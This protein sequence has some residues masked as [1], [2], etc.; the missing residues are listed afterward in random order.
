M[1]ALMSSG[2]Q[3]WRSLRAPRGSSWARFQMC[4]AVPRAGSPSVGAESEAAP[5]AFCVNRVG[6]LCLAVPAY[7]HRMLWGSEGPLDGK[8]K[9]W[10]EDGILVS[11]FIYQL[12]NFEK[13]NLP[14]FLDYT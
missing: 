1:A 9:A 2:A 6:K 13:Y 7:G 5:A 12:S 10:V 3:F 8:L 4:A 11:P 14:H